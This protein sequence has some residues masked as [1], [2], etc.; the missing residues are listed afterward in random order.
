MATQYRHHPT[1]EIIA[2]SAATK[3]FYG[4]IQLCGI[5]LGKVLAPLHAPALVLGSNLDLAPLEGEVLPILVMPFGVTLRYPTKT[6]NYAIRLKNIS[7]LGST[8]YGTRYLIGGNVVRNGRYGMKKSLFFLKF[9]D[10]VFSSVTYK[11]VLILS[12]D[13]T[14]IWY[15]TT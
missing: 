15:R 13:E 14:T 1:P 4:Q 12:Y 9:R 5:I 3:H 7:Q 8:G 10:C 2:A 6:K 11:K